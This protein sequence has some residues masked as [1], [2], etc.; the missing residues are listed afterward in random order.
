MKS[1]LAAVVAVVLSTHAQ[2]R[3]DE[4][5]LTQQ[6]TCRVWTSQAGKQWR[7][8]YEVYINN[9]AVLAGSTARGS[10]LLMQNINQFCIAYPDTLFDDV[11]R[12]YMGRLIGFV[13]K[14]GAPTR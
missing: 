1:I 13:G 3:M 6:I 5:S 12:F 9:L 2:A 8:Q 11:V 14:A 10:V 4:P 7:A